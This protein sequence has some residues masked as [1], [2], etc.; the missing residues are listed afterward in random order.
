MK[1]TI[2]HSIELPIPENIEEET[3]PKVTLHFASPRLTS[4]H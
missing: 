3:V 1:V 4:L 2:G